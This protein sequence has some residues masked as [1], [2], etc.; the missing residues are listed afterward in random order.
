MMLVPRSTSATASRSSRSITA[1]VGL[2]GNGMMTSLVLGVM[3]ALQSVGFEAELV[4]LS[5]GHMARAH[6]RKGW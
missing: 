3:A 1:P 6:R 5:A 4:L 2:L